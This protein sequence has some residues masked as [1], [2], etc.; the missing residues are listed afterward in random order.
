MFQ[1]SN[2]RKQG[3]DLVGLF[4]VVLSLVV[5]CLLAA[6][7]NALPEPPAISFYFTWV[8]CAAVI[9]VWQITVLKLR[10]SHSLAIL[11]TV[12]TIA[13]PSIAGNSAVLSWT[14][15][16][17]LLLICA[18]GI[19]EIFR[20]SAVPAFGKALPCYVVRLSLRLFYSFG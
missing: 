13:L 16:L 5:T 20:Q 3:L 10:V 11:A 19:I 6:S 17:V 18:F 12:A 14:I 15:F 1:L 2:D 7:R 8:H 9:F 4:F